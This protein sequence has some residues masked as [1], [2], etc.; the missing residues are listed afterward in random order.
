MGKQTPNR[1]RVT[2]LIAGAAMVAVFAGALLVAAFAAAPVYA[3]V[4]VL[5]QIFSGTVE[6]NGQPAP[7]GTRIEARGTNVEIGI[8][9]NPITT[10]VVGKYGANAFDRKLAVQGKGLVDGTPIEFYINGYNGS[11]AECAVPGGPWQ[12]SYPFQSQAVT[13]L[14]LKVTVP[15]FVIT[16]T[17]GAHGTIT[18]NTPQTVNY[19]GSA[20][21]TIAADTGYVIDDVTVDGVSQGALPSYTFS[22]VT[23]NHTIAAT[24]RKS[25]IFLPLIV[26]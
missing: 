11:K 24:F 6:I 12:S 17:A 8:P 15:T 9:G 5:P 4:P 18:P 1:Q 16:P 10:T 19:G 26:R 2:F 3:D 20:T 14:N 25:R 21:F 7:A 23:G 13:E 22:N